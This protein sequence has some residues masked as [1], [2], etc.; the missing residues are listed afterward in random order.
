MKK[1]IL[2]L[3]ALLA[4]TSPVPAQQTLPAS[5]VVGRLGIGPGPSQAIPF[6][7]LSGVLFGSGSGVFGLTLSGDANYPMVATDRTVLINAALTAPRTVTLFAAASLAS[8]QQICIGDAFGGVTSTNTLTIARA[9]SDTI[10]GTTSYVLG[11][12]FSD[13]CLISDGSSKWTPI[14]ARMPANTLKG[15]NTAASATPIDLTVAQVKSL[16]SVT[17]SVTDP[18]F[19]AVCDGSTN[20]AV[21]IQAAIDALPAEGGTVL[22]PTGKICKTNSTLNLGNGSTTVASTK[23]GMILSCQ[24]GAVATAYFGNIGGAPTGCKIL[25]GV[26]AGAP[27]IV[28]F[29]PMQGWGI[30]NIYVDCNSVAG[31]GLKIISGI[32]GF[33]RNLTTANCTGQ[34]ILT[35]TVPQ[36]GGSFGDSNTETNIFLNTVVQ[37]PNVASAMG[38]QLTGTGTADTTSNSDFNTFVNT[39]ILLPLTATAM[40]GIGL[41]S[42]DSNV[43]VNTL[44]FGG[45][46]G[47]VAVT[48]DY[49]AQSGLWPA[50]NAFYT[51]DPGTNCTTKFSNTGTPSVNAG[52]KPNYIYGLVETN[53]V[54]APILANLA[55]HS[56][57]SW[58]PNPGNNN[59]RQDALAAW[60]A[61]TPTPTCGTATITSNRARFLSVGKSTYVQ[62]DVT[63]TVLGTC[64]NILA[65]TGPVNASGNGAV[66]GQEIVNTGKGVSCFFQDAGTTV[67]PCRKSDGTNFAVNDRVVISGVYQSP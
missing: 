14:P 56:S 31:V 25:S 18:A 66:S 45:G 61:W 3:L 20:D 44:I 53:G 1:F 51:V 49:S 65:F 40:T 23:R 46:A 4:I 11:S 52:T 7:T 62:L 22:F 6:A 42:S 27:V 67:S 57:N 60:V 13:V 54:T 36:G 17:V 43:F 34:G 48:F 58:I 29:G 35:N 47:C 15:N 9:G 26:G 8:G 32:N 21:A 5:T 16:L 30:E 19:G 2:G 50:S 24:G 37:V 38:I 10:S 55:V 41:Q 64:T 12:A 33:T 39:K 28:V 63:I 59:T